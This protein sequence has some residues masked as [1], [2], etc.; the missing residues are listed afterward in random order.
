[1]GLQ[2]YKAAYLERKEEAQPQKQD[3]G[4]G[5][6]WFSDWICKMPSITIRQESQVGNTR[7]SSE[8]DPLGG[9]IK[10]TTELRLQREGQIL[11]Q[12]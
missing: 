4:K 6:H 1:M 7:L 10:D 12:R 3:L 11:P 5:S 9:S 2:L 8:M